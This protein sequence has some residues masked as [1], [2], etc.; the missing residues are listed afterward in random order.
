MGMNIQLP[1]MGLDPPI[2]RESPDV[3]NIPEIFLSS[4]I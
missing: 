3:Q 4:H 1:A 2:Y